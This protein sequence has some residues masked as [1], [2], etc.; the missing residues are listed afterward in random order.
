MLFCGGQRGGGLWQRWRPWVEFR[1]LTA[2]S[3]S[4]HPKSGRWTRSTLKVSSGPQE[5]FWTMK[6]ILLVS[7]NQ[8]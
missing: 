3:P 5:T 2:P 4:P 8:R 1:G 6:L 7:S